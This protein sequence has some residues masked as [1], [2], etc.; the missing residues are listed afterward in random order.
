MLALNTALMT[1]G[2]A[3]RIGEGVILDN[4]SAAPLDVYL[5]IERF[6]LPGFDGPDVD[7]MKIVE[8][9]T[10]VGH[11]W[12]TG[13]G[14]TSFGHV[15][16]RGAI[17]VGAAAWYETPRF[18]VSPPLLEPYSAAGGIPILFDPAGERLAAPIVRETP[19]LVAPDGGNTTF[20]SGDIPQD[21]DASPNFFGTSA[22]A[23]HAAGV[24]ALLQGW[25]RREATPDELERLLESTAVEMSA[26]GYDLDTG[27]GLLDAHAA[28]EMLSRFLRDPL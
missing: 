12:N 8:F 9:L 11:E 24:A 10:R 1:G 17:A 5:S 7:R 14:A 22:S 20:F 19:D 26:P 13:D 4:P 6:K 18:G 2:I 21:A 25:V 23:A 28:F 15:N 16:A 27:H 3:L